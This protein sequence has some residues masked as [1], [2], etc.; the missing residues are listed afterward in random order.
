VYNLLEIV[1]N[2]VDWACLDGKREKA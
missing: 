2:F 1:V